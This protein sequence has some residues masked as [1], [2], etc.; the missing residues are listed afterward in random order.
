MLKQEAM[1]SFWWNWSWMCVFKVYFPTEPISS[2][3]NLVM[4]VSYLHDVNKRYTNLPKNLWATSKFYAHS[5]QTVKDTRFGQLKG[6][7]CFAVH[8]TLVNVTRF[9][10]FYKSIMWQYA[11]FKESSSCT[12]YKMCH[13]MSCTCT[14][15]F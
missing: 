10:F 13:N 14:T 6:P 15:I 3:T 12:I 1:M 2:A 8:L 9:G 7:R 11:M 4:L 5:P